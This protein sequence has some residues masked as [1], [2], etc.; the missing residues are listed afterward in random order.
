MTNAY[1][2][3]KSHLNGF[4]D[5]L[6]DWLKIPSISTDPAF[7]DQVRRSAEWL[8]ADMRRI[9]LENVE[10]LETGGH[11]VVYADWLHAGE[12]APTILVYGHYDVQPAV[13]IDGW[14]HDPFQPEIR[15]GKLYARGA[16]D[17]KG[18]VMIQLKALECLL[19][20]G[21]SPVNVKYLIEGEEEIGSPYLAPFIRA[22][23]D[24]LRADICLISDTGILRPDQPSLV[25]AL[26]GL[27]T[28]QLTVTGPQRDLHSGLGGMIHNPAQ[29]LVEIVAQLHTPDGR[30]A[31]PGFYDEVIELAP[32]ERDA[33]KATD[34]QD[35]EWRAM[36][37]DL[38]DWG[39]SAYTRGER[40]GARPTL[41]VNGIA[42][43][44]A[45]DGFK[46][47][48]PARAIAKLSCRLVP[49]QNPDVIFAKIKNFIEHI[50]PPTVHVELTYFDKGEPAM[51]PI[52]HP[53]V[54][55]A[56]RAYGYAWEKPVLFQ[57]GGGSIPI[58]ADIQKIFDIPVV[59]L[60]FSL[61]DAGAH[62]PN[63][64]F[65]LDIFHKGIQTVITY[66]R[67]VAA[68]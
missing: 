19:A 48:L 57:R 31:V 52:D 46:T 10:I 32:A 25:Y 18:Q 17:D 22:N 67:E 39:E 62:G 15:D 5:Q 23:Q 64:H 11:P 36:M 30:V 61:P 1:D 16:A 3:A 9:G 44:Y 68:S 51:T 53:A 4:Q 47:V 12:S 38:P 27:V 40:S 29:A 49:N 35:D 7:R 43:G 63:E 14:L 56:V 13:V 66:F 41:E 34:V 59:L 20:T 24:K 45:G 60:G 42:G 21:G 58:V 50:S 26:R 33:L 6:V 65:H 55:A 54:Q 28:M 8:A 37:G 2:Y